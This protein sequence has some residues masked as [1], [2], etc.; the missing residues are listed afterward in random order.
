MWKDTSTHRH[1]PS[2]CSIRLADPVLR[3]PRQKEASLASV[4]ERVTIGGYIHTHNIHMR[5]TLWLF[6]TVGYK[7]NKSNLKRETKEM[8]T[9]SSKQSWSQYNQTS[10]FSGQNQN[11]VW[12]LKTTWRVSLERIYALSLS[13]W[14]CHVPVPTKAGWEPECG[15]RWCMLADGT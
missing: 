11:E 8:K 2:P 3:A 13:S 9:L 5:R 12:T 4:D 1:L 6:T 14:H 7:G 15:R 10:N